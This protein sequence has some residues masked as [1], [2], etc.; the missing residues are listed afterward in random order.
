MVQRRDDAWRQG[1]EVFAIDG[2][3]GAS[4]LAV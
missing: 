2:F 4:Q 3:A 1:P